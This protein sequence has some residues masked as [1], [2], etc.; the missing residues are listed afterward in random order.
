MSV[1]KILEERGERYGDFANHAQITQEIKGIMR[2]MKNWNR[3]S[4]SQAEALEMIAHKMARILNGDPNYIDNWDDI[5][6][7]ATLVAN[8]LRKENV[9]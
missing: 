7:Y 9:T 4:N 5:S 2:S 6:G 8:E 1:D 3:L